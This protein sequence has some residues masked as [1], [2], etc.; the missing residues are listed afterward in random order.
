MATKIEEMKDVFISSDKKYI[1]YMLDYIK[2]DLG[3]PEADYFTYCGKYVIC[4]PKDKYESVLL[5]GRKFACKEENFN[6]FWINHYNERRTEIGACDI[7]YGRLPKTLIPG[8]EK[9][10]YGDRFFWG[11]FDDR[12]PRTIL[13]YLDSMKDYLKV[14]K[15]IREYNRVDD[16]L[17]IS[18][19]SPDYEEKSKLFREFVEK[20][21]YGPFKDIHSLTF[22][23]EYV[24]QPILVKKNK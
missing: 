18:P 22:T 17:T 4:V 24:K 14:D 11:C 20:Y 9:K 8:E 19:L 15:I 7:G 2:N 1:L 5:N 23:G 3:I 16:A 12:T 21:G 13:E 6:I 10:Q